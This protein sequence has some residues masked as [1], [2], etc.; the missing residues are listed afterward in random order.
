MKVLLIVYVDDFKMAGT[1]ADV[2]KTWDMIRKC[3]VTEEDAAGKLVE[4]EA[5]KLGENTGVNN[6]LG[7][8]HHV[9][10]FDLPGGRKGQAMVYEM[11]EF[12]NRVWSATWT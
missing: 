5:V 7:C 2:A 11:H 10:T 8:S 12:M 1:P 3:T 6:F 9:R 4:V